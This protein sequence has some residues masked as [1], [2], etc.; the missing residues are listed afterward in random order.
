MGGDSSSAPLNATGVDFSDPDQAADFLSALLDD[1]QLKA[2]GNAYARYFN[3]GLA[4]VVGLATL[5]RLARWLLLKSRLRA[6]A[7]DKQKPAMPRSLPMQ[8]LATITAMGREATYL[9]FTP[10]TRLMW[11]RVPT[12]GNLL[13]VATHLVFILALEFV[14]NDTPGAQYWQALGVRA[15]WLAVAQMPLLILLIGKN[16]LIGLLTGVSYER[17]NVFHRWTARFLLLMAIFHFAFQS[18]AWNEFGLMQLEWTTDT[19]PPTGIAAF[20]VLLWINLSTLA[21][22]RHLSYEFFVVQ[23]IVSFI[24]FI[25]AIMYHLPSTALW[26]RIYLY[27]PIA[28]YLIDRIVRTVWVFMAN[29][30]RSRALITPLEG[31]VTKVQI[32]TKGVKSWGPGSHMLLHIPQFGFM[33]NHPAT[34]VSTPESHNGDLVFILKSHKGFTRRIMTGANS[35]ATALLL[36]TKNK[37]DQV[38]HTAEVVSHWAILDGPYGGSQSDFAA[39][40][41]ACLIAGSTGVTFTLALLLDL[42]D[43]ASVKKLP[44]RRLHFVWCVKDS[45]WAGW[46]KAEIVT[47]YEKLGAAGIETKISIFV[48]CSDLYTEQ[49][50]DK[51]ECGCQCDKSLGPYCCVV[52]DE[53]AGE[54]S[55]KAEDDAIVLADTVAKSEPNRK[56]TTVAERPARSSASSALESGVQAPVKLPILPCADFYSGRPAIADIINATLAG[57][58]GESAVAV[59]GPIGL[60]SSVRNTVVRLSDQRAIH[61]GSG[62]Q[63]C[64]LHVE[65]FS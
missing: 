24:G 58:E 34:I 26:S 31:G 15:G 36:Q 55:S 62:A 16:N 59:C 35:S 43:K 42:A 48:T 29:A 9:Q 41:S 57:A 8:W 28:L 22:F 25:V 2:V 23:H 39:F 11:F 44:L 14:D 7:Q 17:L 6:A 3:Y 63:G 51:K 30:R 10:K 13:L 32:K 38:P 65:S 60:N 5:F 12:M 40:D 56:E 53:D 50:N 37:E 45:L 64:Y 54:G 4:V 61:K 20:A 49:G 21:P 46:A 47:A 19:C 33:Q 1:D 27:I 52:V 18:T